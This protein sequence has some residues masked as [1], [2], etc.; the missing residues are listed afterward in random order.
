MTTQQIAINAAAIRNLAA[1]LE[2]M[3]YAGGDVHAEAEHIA[4]NLLADGC[5]PVEPPVPLHGPSSTPAGRAKARALLA[6]ALR[7]K[8]K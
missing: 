7:E 2:D 8:G 4:L 1:R 3:G 5:R 6:E